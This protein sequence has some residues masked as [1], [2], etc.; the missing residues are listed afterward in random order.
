MAAKKIRE[1]NVA[2]KNAI[3]E[4]QRFEEKTEE[5]VSSTGSLY[6]VQSTNGVDFE[7]DQL[8]IYLRF[9]SVWSD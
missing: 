1:N 2:Y 6:R 8:L 7:L 5:A 3:R 4:Y 9:I